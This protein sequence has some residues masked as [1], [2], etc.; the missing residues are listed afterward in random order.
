MNRLTN[1]TLAVAV[2]GLAVTVLHAGDLGGLLSA[3][4]AL[5]SG[6]MMLAFVGV[7]L[8]AVVGGGWRPRT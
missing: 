1:I 5:A 2:F 7:I 4:W 8:V 3:A 6:A